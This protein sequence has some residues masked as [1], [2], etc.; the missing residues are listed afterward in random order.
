M[1]KVILSNKE[2]TEKD[3][4]NKIAKN[5]DLN[6]NYSDPF[7]KYKINK[8]ATELIE[9]I[10]SEFK[11]R[12]LKI[13]ELGCGTGEYTLKVAKSLPYSKIVGLDISDKI[14]GLAKIKCKEVKN[15]SFVVASAYDTAFPDNYFDVIF[16]YYVLHHLDTKRTFDEIRR[17][18]KPGGFAFFYEPNILNPLVYMI[19]SN[20][21]LKKKVGDSPNEWA[22]NPLSLKHELKGFDNVTVSTREYVIPLK[23]IPFRYLK[24]IDI[25]SR[26][27]KKIPLLNYFGGSVQISFKK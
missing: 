25:L 20:K 22:I 23:L 26:I 16:G 9:L 19:K 7:T 17:L 2:I 12:N 21:H 5:Y 11:R 3:Y 13:L 1:G 15:I 6:Y 8:K 24:K 14:V 27:F 4:F 18:L 10:K